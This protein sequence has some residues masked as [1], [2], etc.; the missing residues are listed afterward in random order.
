MILKGA[1]SVAVISAVVG[2][3]LIYGMK[4]KYLKE[5]YMLTFLNEAMIMKNKRIESY[6]D[7][8]IKSK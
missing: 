1:I 6:L 7:S 4:K 8:L 3:W 2:L 5:V